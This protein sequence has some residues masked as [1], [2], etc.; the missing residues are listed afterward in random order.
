MKN[1]SVGWNPGKLNP[2]IVKPAG[3]IDPA[4]PVVYAE[5][6][7]GQPLAT[8]VNFAM[9]LDTTGGMLFSSDYAHPLAQILSRVK[10]PAC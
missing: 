10:S 3:P 7:G 8:Y 4:V 9:H 1:G 2:N 6:L 5:T